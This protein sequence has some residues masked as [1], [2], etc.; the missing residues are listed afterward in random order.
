MTQLVNTSIINLAQNS[1]NK[2][3]SAGINEYFKVKNPT[4]PRTGQ[5]ARISHKGRIN[6]KNNTFVVNAATQYNKLPAELRKPSITTTKFKKELKAHMSTQY[7][8]AKH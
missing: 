2:K 1:I 5:G 7:L 4:N 8:L 6:D 3:S